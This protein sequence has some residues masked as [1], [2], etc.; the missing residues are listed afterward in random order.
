MT[1]ELGAPILVGETTAERLADRF[2]LREIGSV[3]IRGKQAPARVFVLIGPA[4]ADQV[5]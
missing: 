5:A 4:R 2:E 3:T 1:T